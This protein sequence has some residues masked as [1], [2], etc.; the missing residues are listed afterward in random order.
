MAGRDESVW[1]LPADAAS[2]YDA[3]FRLIDIHGNGRISRTEAV[4]LFERSELPDSE[5]LL[6]WSL[7]DVDGDGML[8]L[9]EF[10]VAM[11]LTTLAVDRY[12]LPARLPLA[13]QEH[14]RGELPSAAE[15]PLSRAATA[16]APRGGGLHRGT[17]E[18]A[19]SI[20]PTELAHYRAVFLSA[21]CERGKGISA[22]EAAPILAQTGLTEEEL[23][24]IWDL[25]NISE[26]GRLYA[27]FTI[28]K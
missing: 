1:K 10:R 15:R 5:L 13:L 17:S 28:L 18:S 11:H 2:R 4:P 21:E 19:S 24:Q 6:I 14:A 23:D 9:T 27:P 26:E 12:P 20:A 3:Y 8:S 7:A 25:A 22:E 16:S